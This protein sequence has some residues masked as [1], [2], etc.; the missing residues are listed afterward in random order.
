MIIS[1]ILLLM[2]LFVNIATKIP[3]HSMNINFHFSLFWNVST[4]LKPKMGL[5]EGDGRTIDPIECTGGNEEFT[6]LILQM[7]R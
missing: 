5:E 6:L 3:P 2:M 7:K 1:Y 4:K